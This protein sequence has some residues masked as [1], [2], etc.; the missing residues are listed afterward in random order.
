MLHLR[1]GA[2]SAGEKWWRL[3]LEESYAEN[4][5]SKIA[6]SNNI[7][8]RGA[9]SITAGLFL[10]QFIDADKMEWAHLDIAGPCW[11]DNLGG[12]TGFGATTLATW[13]EKEAQ[14]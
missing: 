4:L 1:R 8:G 11:D 10:K 5:K 7:A 13:V 3:P 12:A 14:E 6:D 2:L 9:G